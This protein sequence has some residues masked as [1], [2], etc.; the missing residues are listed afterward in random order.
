MK[1]YLPK[2]TGHQLQILNKQLSHAQ[3]DLNEV[4]KLALDPK[5]KTDANILAK[6]FE[7]LI[8]KLKEKYEVLIK[9]QLANL[10]SP[11]KNKNKIFKI[12]LSQEQRL[13][14]LK[15]STGYNNS[16]QHVLNAKTPQEKIKALGKLL[17]KKSGSFLL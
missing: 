7:K 12:S 5:K 8:A 10:P 15:N 16:A 1:L 11:P 9:R 6:D 14:N 3:A 4:R 17:R 2:S 13:N